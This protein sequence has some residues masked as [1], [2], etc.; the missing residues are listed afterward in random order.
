MA[1][2]KSSNNNV[3]DILK[4]LRE[5]LS[6]AENSGEPIKRE[7]SKRERE[8]ECVPCTGWERRKSCCSWQATGANSVGTVRELLSFCLFS[9]ITDVAR[10]QL[11]FRSPSLSLSLSY[12]LSVALSGVTR[13]LAMPKLSCLASSSSSLLSFTAISVRVGRRSV[14]A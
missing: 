3:R 5:N 2:Y 10:G 12:C 14:R 6:V 7:Q 4:S 9:F 8:R 11:R 13:T 1:T